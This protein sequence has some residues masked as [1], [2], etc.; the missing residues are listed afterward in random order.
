[1]DHLWIRASI[2]VGRLRQGL[3]RSDETQKYTCIHY[4]GPGSFGNFRNR[5][6]SMIIQ[7]FS[8][9]LSS[10]SGNRDWRSRNFMDKNRDLENLKIEKNI[11][12]KGVENPL[13]LENNIGVLYVA[14]SFGCGLSPGPSFEIQLCIHRCYLDSKRFDVAI[15]KG[16]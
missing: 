9:G 10:K 11:F 14:H 5:K 15:F 1:M 16:E 2:S 12:F 3:R 4:Y 7:N 6:F 13:P 8:F